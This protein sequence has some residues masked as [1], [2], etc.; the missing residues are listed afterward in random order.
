MGIRRKQLMG[1]FLSAAL[2]AGSILVPVSAKEKTDVT[3]L[4]KVKNRTEYN[5][6]RRAAGKNQAEIHVKKYRS[7][8][9]MPGEEGYKYSSSWQGKT[10]KIY[11]DQSGLLVIGGESEDMADACGTLYDASGKEVKEYQK[12]GLLM[13]VVS[14]GTVYSLKLPEKFRSFTVEADLME[15]HQKVLR[16][17][18]SY[19][20]TVTG[21]Y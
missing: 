4:L 18:D 10:V 7:I 21:G 17:N 20:Q 12:E 16:K 1:I 13:K 9:E 3:D 8:G 2:A 5:K 6:G 14:A 19:V 11:A 15:D